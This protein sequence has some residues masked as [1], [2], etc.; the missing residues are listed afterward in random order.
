VTADTTK[1]IDGYFHDYVSIGF[2][3]QI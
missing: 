2:V 1:S 3:L